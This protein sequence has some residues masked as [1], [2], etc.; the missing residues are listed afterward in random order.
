MG[1]GVY[2]AD[3]WL[4]SVALVE[5]DLVATIVAPL[6]LSHSKPDNRGFTLLSAESKSEDEEEVLLTEEMDVA[7]DAPV[8]RLSIT[9][10]HGRLSWN[11]RHGVGSRRSSCRGCF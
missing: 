3:V 8:Q 9:S 4:I 11:T 10:A 5:A 6:D 7:S 1:G 2:K